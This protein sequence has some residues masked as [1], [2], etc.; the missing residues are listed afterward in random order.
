VVTVLAAEEA[1]ARNLLL[2]APARVPEQPAGG[3]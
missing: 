2:G 3:A 1:G